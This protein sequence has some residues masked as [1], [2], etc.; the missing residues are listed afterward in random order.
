MA[1]SRRQFQTDLELS[2]SLTGEARHIN[3]LW[4]R[5]TKIQENRLL[6]LIRVMISAHSRPY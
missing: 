6:L 5:Q 1:I 3:K 4:R 2:Q